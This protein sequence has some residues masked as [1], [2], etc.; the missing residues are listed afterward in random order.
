MSKPPKRK[1]VKSPPAL[2]KLS[3]H[4]RL[5]NAPLS[6]QAKDGVMPRPKGGKR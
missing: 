6:R 5:G 4:L 1:K 2:P 3:P